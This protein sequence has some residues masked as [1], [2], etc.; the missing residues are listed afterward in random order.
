MY[1][2]GFQPLISQVNMMEISHSGIISHKLKAWFMKELNADFK[3]LNL[4]IYVFTY[5]VYFDSVI[6]AMSRHLYLQQ[7]AVFKNPLSLRKPMGFVESQSSNKIIW[8]TIWDKV[9]LITYV[10]KV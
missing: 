1:D 7:F 6:S 8:H 2:D 10:N 3:E 5:D 4:N 9:K